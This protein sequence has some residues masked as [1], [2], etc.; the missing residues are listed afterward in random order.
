MH[1]QRLC[2]YCPNK[3]EDEFH[4]IAEYNLSDD[5]RKIY[6]YYK[7]GRSMFNVVQPI[8]RYLRARVKYAFLALNHRQNFIAICNQCL[9]AHV[10]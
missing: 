6:R 8:A 1:L 3:I 2:P 5:F 7:Q 4:L 9:S 10:Y